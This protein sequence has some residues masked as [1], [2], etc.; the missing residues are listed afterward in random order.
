MLV[1]WSVASVLQMIASRYGICATY[2]HRLVVVLA[3]SVLFLRL[4]FMSLLRCFLG[5][6]LT[7]VLH[8]TQ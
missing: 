2:R 6:Q 8:Y 5:N 7:T 1:R 3:F 4:A